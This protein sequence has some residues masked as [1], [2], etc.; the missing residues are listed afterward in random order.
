VLF[1]PYHYYLSLLSVNFGPV[2]TLFTL[3]FLQETKE[4]LNQATGAGSSSYYLI[5]CYPLM[6][7]CLNSNR[8][9]QEYYPME[10][11]QVINRFWRS[12]IYNCN[13]N[14]ICRWKSIDRRQ[15]F[16]SSLSKNTYYNYYYFRNIHFYLLRF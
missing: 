6:L 1:G 12:N 8:G 9:L 11:M 4:L 7:F 10:L 15:Q 3:L 16:S 13:W 5:P 14:R 2:L